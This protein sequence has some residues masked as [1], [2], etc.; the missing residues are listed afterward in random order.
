MAE[1]QAAGDRAGDNKKQRG[2]V[3]GGLLQRE[4]ERLRREAARRAW[5][6]EAAERETAASVL[7]SCSPTAPALND[8]T[9]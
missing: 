2:K 1:T 9:M 8:Q 4:A 3:A 7:A 6:E 5:R